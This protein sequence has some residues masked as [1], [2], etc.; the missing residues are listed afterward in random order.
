MYRT[1][2]SK[3]GHALMEVITQLFLDLCFLQ[4]RTRFFLLKFSEMYID[5]MSPLAIFLVTHAVH[6]DCLQFGGLA[7]KFQ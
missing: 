5:F 2:T 4:C 6:Y 3:Q 7:M 1:F